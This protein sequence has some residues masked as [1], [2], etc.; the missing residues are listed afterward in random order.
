MPVDEGGRG[1]QD[2][3]D[4]HRGQG[5]RHAAGPEAARLIQAIRKDAPSATATAAW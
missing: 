2:M 1:D 4:A 5:T 3:G